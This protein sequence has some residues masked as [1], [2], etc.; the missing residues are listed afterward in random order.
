MQVPTAAALGNG[1]TSSSDDGADAPLHLAESDF[2][3]EVSPTWARSG[4]RDGSPGSE[5]LMTRQR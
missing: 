4:S 1:T 3:G 5:Y 2:E